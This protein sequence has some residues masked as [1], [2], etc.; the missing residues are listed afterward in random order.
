MNNQNS[1]EIKNLSIDN[2]KLA[3]VMTYIKKDFYKI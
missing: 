1:A 2:F 3:G